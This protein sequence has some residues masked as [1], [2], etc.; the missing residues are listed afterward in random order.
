[1]SRRMSTKD[2]FKMLDIL[3]QDTAP[4]KYINPDAWI[5]P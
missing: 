3:W 5:V 2:F 1:M 4:V